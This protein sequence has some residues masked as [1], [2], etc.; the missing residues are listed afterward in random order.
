M[1]NDSKHLLLAFL[2]VFMVFFVG[3]YFYWIPL[4]KDYQ[5][6][7]GELAQ[8]ESELERIETILKQIESDKS[9]SP[10]R[11]SSM[12]FPSE[13]S[14][15]LKML[16]DLARRTV[17]IESFEIL[18]TF[19]IKP[20]DSFHFHQPQQE[21]YNIQELPELDDSGMPIGIEYQ[22]SHTE[23]EGVEVVPVRFRFTAR[24]NRFGSFLNSIETT[25]PLSAVRLMDIMTYRQ[26]IVRGTITLVFPL[27]KD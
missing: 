16:N 12:L 11:I 2:F 17:I 3:S 6:L 1:T 21:S 24:F 25:L 10:S 14:Q 22:H 26:G 13:E 27:Y 20:E 7:I 19:F 15:I 9:V 18:P 4:E 8:K 5:E 23:W